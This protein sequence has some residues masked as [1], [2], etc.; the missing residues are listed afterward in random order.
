MMIRK[1]FVSA[2]AVLV[3]AGMTAWADEAKLDGVKCVVAPRA[4]KADQSVD[5]KDAKVYFCCGNCP[6]KFAEAPEKFATTA[7]QQLVA[8]GQYEQKKCP[9]TGG[10]IN[11]ETAIKVG[12]AKVAFCCTNCQGKVKAAEAKEQLEMV[13]AEKPFEKAGFAKVEKK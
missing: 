11:P 12:D 9:L 1:F 7:N 3:V 2:F 10:P 13:F 5:Y 8:T 4:A 6:K